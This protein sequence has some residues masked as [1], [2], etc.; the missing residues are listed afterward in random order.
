MSERQCPEA[1]HIVR[2]HIREVYTAERE[3]DP[4]H[5]DTMYVIEVIV[6]KV[7]KGKGLS[8]DKPL[9]VRGW[10]SKL[11][12]AGFDGPTGQNTI[13]RPFDRVWVY[14]RADRDGGYDLLEPNGIEIFLEKKA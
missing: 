2:G 1:T 12:P 8:T 4:G 5:V 6:D 9:Y 11:R 3:S 7:D 13:P 10:K 14:F